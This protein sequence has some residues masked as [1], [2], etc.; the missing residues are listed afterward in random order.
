MNKIPAIAG[1][2]IRY[3]HSIQYGKDWKFTKRIKYFSNGHMEL[4][5]EYTTTNIYYYFFDT[6]TVETAWLSYAIFVPIPIPPTET[7][8][9]CN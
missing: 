7:I 9:E 5:I 3:P 4:E 8:I 6:D 2:V 1:Y